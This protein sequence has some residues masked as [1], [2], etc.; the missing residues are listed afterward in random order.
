MQASETFRATQA[1]LQA[2]YRM[3][4]AKRAYNELEEEK[5]TILVNQLSQCNNLPRIPAQ[6]IYG[7]YKMR[8]LLET[9]LGTAADISIQL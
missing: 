7:F 6:H 5:Y 1:S 9:W 2:S 8:P 4:Y 3:T